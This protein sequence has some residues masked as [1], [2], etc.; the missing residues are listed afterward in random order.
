MLKQN[1][2][3]GGIGVWKVTPLGRD[4]ERVRVQHAAPRDDMTEDVA[5]VEFMDR[6]SSYLDGPGKLVDQPFAPRLSEGMIRAYSS[7][8]RSSGLP[9]SNRSPV[10]RSQRSGT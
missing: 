4:A 2:G 3:N 10:G 9:A 6:W 8:E 1:R 5:L 7:N